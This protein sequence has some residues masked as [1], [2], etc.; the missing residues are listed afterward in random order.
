MET[1]RVRLGPGRGGAT[2][3]VDDRRVSKNMTDTANQVPRHVASASHTHHLVHVYRPGILIPPT[4]AVAVF[5][6]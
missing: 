3:I 1:P 6:G 4:R 2:A 5:I